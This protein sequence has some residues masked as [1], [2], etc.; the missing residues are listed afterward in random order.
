M[1]E[2]LSLGREILR[3]EALAIQNLAEQLDSRFQQAVRLIL[4]CQGT[5]VV[6]GVGKAGIVG[7]KISAT[8]S[9]T[10]SPSHF[11]HPTEALHGDLGK[12]IGRAHV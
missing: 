9:S 5:V 11:L 4:H 12:E 8:L 10:G 2:V 6:C 1:H 7:Q 3:Q